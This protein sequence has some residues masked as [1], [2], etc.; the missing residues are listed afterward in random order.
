MNYHAKKKFFF[1]FAIISILFSY[2]ASHIKFSDIHNSKFHTF[3]IKF[4]YYGIDPIAIEKIITKPLEEKFCELDSLYELKST[5]RFNE[6]ITT[7]WFYSS[8]NQDHIY[9]KIRKITEDLYNSLPQNVQ[10][11][12]IYN[13]SS[14]DKSITCIAINCPDTI[15]EKNIKP[16]L[17]SIPGVSEVIISGKNNQTVSIQ[18]DNKHISN[19]H[20]IPS[21]ISKAV[22]FFNAP[23]LIASKKSGLFKSSFF[24]KNKIESKEELSD[25][26]LFQGKSTLNLSTIADIN[27]ST[28]KQNEL[29]LLNNTKTAYINIKASEN[30]N[31]INISEKTHTLLNKAEYKKY[32]P[33]FL[34][35]T[36]KKQKNLLLSVCGTL[37]IT[38]ILNIIFSYLF[39]RSIKLSLIL[40]VIICSAILWTTG[41]LSI[42]NISIN[43]QILSGISLSTGLIADTALVIFEILNNSV[44]K[45]IFFKKVNLTLSAASASTATTLIAVI[46]LFFMTDIT[47][48]IKSSGISIF[49]MLIVSSVISLF[50]LPPF[51]PDILRKKYNTE[52]ITAPLIKI[53]SQILKKRNTL[54]KIF[55][56]SSILSIVLFIIS[57]KNISQNDMSDIIYYSIEYNP[58]KKI[59]SIHT[60]LT[61]Y[62]NEISKI[63]QIDFIKSTILRGKVEFEVIHSSN[64]KSKIIKQ[65]ASKS[66]LIKDG[67]VYIPSGSEKKYKNPVTLQIAVT[68]DDESKCRALAKEAAFLINKNNL[69][70]QTT[71]N[72]KEEEKMFSYIPSKIKLA[73]LN[74][75]T[76]DAAQQLR[77]SIFD[78]VISK[79]F[80]NNNETDVTLSST[81][82]KKLPDITELNFITRDD[83][84]RI[85][86]TGILKEDKIP[87]QIHRLDSQPCAYF[88]IELNKKTFTREMNKIKRILS[89]IKKQEGYKFIFPSSI[90][91]NQIAYKKLSAII[92]FCIFCIYCFLTAQNEDF[93]ISFSIL[94]CIPS[95]LF[96][97]LSIRLITRTAISFGDT[98]GIILLSGIVINNSIYI[99]EAPEFSVIKKINCRIESILITSLTTILG[100]LPMMCLSHSQFIKSLSFF[101]TFGILN[102]LIVS[103]FLFPSMLDDA[104]YSVLKHEVYYTAESKQTS[105]QKDIHRQMSRKTP[106][107]FP[108]K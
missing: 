8:A 95:S 13:S 100:S 70:L 46:P 108:R 89:S 77:Y 49:T 53:I 30:S 3:S 78:S 44:S 18:F 84:V 59:D 52:S 76:F 82:S 104:Y 101:M 57:D 94:C 5:C 2:S 86:S 63:S 107:T 66:G 93:K 73:K 20:I 80:I 90:K 51:L 22:N 1:V 34:Y 4:K 81:N 106:R 62:I 50:F 32:N 92:F 29:E 12:E 21:N 88:S 97:P 83:S 72:F 6:S 43:E 103:L 75:S 40:S 41:L 35:D 37:I 47:P 38:I 56:F 45:K 55:L 96:L 102:S 98:V 68:G 10:R 99:S 31:K 79:I 7:A 26:Q 16:H 85:S 25:I 27:F 64:S 14:E 54:K 67:D 74:L 91:Q 39:Y 69:S 15:L 9:L 33:V 23:N 48:G 58:E 65:I 17:E 61:P 105:D 19:Y 24:I 42:I 60:E 71:L 28:Q 36:G 87:S 11:P